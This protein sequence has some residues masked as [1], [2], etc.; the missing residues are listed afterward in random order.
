[1]QGRLRLP[2]DKSI[3]H[4]ALL[5]G[6]I[7]RG[8]TKIEGLADGED[9]QT[10]AGALRQLGVSIER[11]VART[12]VHGVGR[13]GL[14]TPAGPLYLGNSGT[15]ARLLAGLLAAQPF[16]ATL[17]GDSSLSQRPMRRI[18]E[19]LRRMGGCIEL[20]TNG[21][22]PAHVRG[23]RLTGIDYR[24]PMASAQVKSCLLLAGLYADGTTCVRESLPTRDHTEILL[25]R[26]GYALRRAPGQACLE[27]GGELRATTIAVPA[28]LSSAAFFL[29]GA[30]M[31]PGSDLVLEGAGVNPTRRAALDILRAMGADIGEE[32]P[33]RQS[34]EPVADLHVRAA[35]RLIGIRI[36]PELSGAA[37]DELPALA[38][39]AAGAEGCTKIRG[40]GELR[41]KE[42]DRI[43][44]LCEGLDAL[45]I[46]ARPH[47]DGLDIEGGY[48]SGGRVQSH[49]DHR[50]AMA[51]AMA[52]LAARAEVRVQ[53][54]S[55]VATS[56]PGFA[57]RARRAG[58]QLECERQRDAS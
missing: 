35:R 2:G 24:L 30:S 27:G 14:R 41:F 10:T 21:T 39:A 36:P 13:S 48:L 40:A 22:L 8:Q 7:A 23:N 58:L 28:D 52:G 55:C 20:D 5:L 6:A 46:R 38:I 51:F 37:I 56:F 16:A 26:F 49:G 9:V 3:S 42:S 33:R 50:I 25:E 47:E 44:S 11:E 32:N 53:D 4:R 19:P 18:E 17:T 57:E 15:T 29:V 12:V 54:C 31:A 43:R 1:M 34:G 45:G